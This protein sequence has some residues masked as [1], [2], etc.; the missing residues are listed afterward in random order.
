MERC[1]GTRLNGERAHCR[2]S[3][4]LID[5]ITSLHL[6]LVSNIYTLPVGYLKIDRQDHA[7]RVIAWL[8]Y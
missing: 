6:V 2:N 4:L 8:P 7:I 5:G 1:A 3:E